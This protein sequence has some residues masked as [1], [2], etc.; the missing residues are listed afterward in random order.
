[1]TKN[2][3]DGLL[4]LLLGIAI[5]A[6][7]GCAFHFMLTNSM[8][9]FRGVYNATQSMLEHRDPYRVNT[10]DDMH[11]EFGD[12][13]LP[14][15]GVPNRSVPLYVYLPLSTSIF[16]PFAL[17]PWKVAEVLWT[18]CF[19][20]CMILAAYLVWDVSAVYAPRISGGLICIL[21]SNCVVVFANGN[22]AG[23]AVALSVIGAWCFVSERFVP[24]GMI[25]LALSLIIKPHDSGLVWLCFLLTGGAYRKRSILTFALVVLLGLPTLFWM[26]LVSPH[27]IVELR[28][29]LAALGGHG[30]LS[31]PGPAGP[32]S[33]SVQPIID[34]QAGVAYLRDD[35]GLYSLIAY[36]ICSALAL[37]WSI[38]ALRVPASR[39]Q[40]WF[41]I[42]FASVLTML[43]T[44]HRPYDAKLL[45]LTVPACAILWSEGGMTGWMALVIGTLG[46]VFTGEIPLAAMGALASKLGVGK[47]GFSERLLT[48]AIARPASLVLLVMGVFYL[49]VYL[50]RSGE[51][52]NIEAPRQK[53]ENCS[54]DF[55]G[56]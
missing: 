18:I 32:F 49:W 38:G 9:D 6:V 43:V 47:G 56:S 8:D 42:A 19:A 17:L 46:M 4:L 45:L 39:N 26:G 2:Q 1:M 12:K 16:V 15:V 11:R 53:C 41:E 27:W 35:P 21:L 50:K 34:L 3:Q 33:L 13:N 40:L 31:D 36:A 20:V 23:L 10:L 55:S 44:Y 54:G 22:P 52:K 14:G 48:V 28:A 30:G 29:N 5:L 25:C 24:V 7:V 37:I 51:A